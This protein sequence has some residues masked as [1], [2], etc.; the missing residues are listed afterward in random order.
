MTQKLRY[1]KPNPGFG[2]VETVIGAAIISIILIGLAEVGRFTFR[3]VDASNFKIRASFL[4]EEGI[5]AV[6]GLR[7]AGFTA[8]ITPI[9][10]DTDYYLSFSSGSWNL[11]TIPSP[12]VDSAFSRTV[13]FSAVCRD[14]SDAIANCG[15]P[16]VTDLNTKKVT[17][18]VGWVDRGK[19][20]TTTIETYITNFHAN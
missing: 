10:L 5:E 3:L 6:R 8:Y 18:A 17:V 4:T 16:P 1:S 13:R 9:L 12:L 19:A 11:A 15:T 7:D 20:G 14:A 2:L